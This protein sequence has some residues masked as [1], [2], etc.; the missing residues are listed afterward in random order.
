MG[1][2]VVSEWELKIDKQTTRKAYKQIKYSSAEICDCDDCKNYVKV[3]EQ[4]LYPK[5][6][7]KIFT[8]FGINPIKENEICSLGFQSSKLHRYSGWM[9]FVGEII[10]GPVSE[11]VHYSQQKEEIRQI[12]FTQISD[13]FSISIRSRCDLAFEAFL[14]INKPI[15]QLEFLVILPWLL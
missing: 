7:E 14:H 12:V 2:I 13:V 1:K 3:K 8:G 9:H 15:L 10:K 11:V 5:E 6:A 4:Q